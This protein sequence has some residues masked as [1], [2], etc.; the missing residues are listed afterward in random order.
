MDQEA[1]GADGGEGGVRR[2]TPHPTP[3]PATG[4]G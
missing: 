3:S 4:E 2:V 1:P